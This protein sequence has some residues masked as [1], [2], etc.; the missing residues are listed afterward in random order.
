MRKSCIIPAV[1]LTLLIHVKKSIIILH[2]QIVKVTQLA[3]GKAKVRS[4][5][6]S[7]VWF[8]LFFSSVLM[9]SLNYI[10]WQGI[11][12]SKSYIRINVLFKIIAYSTF[13]SP[14]KIKLIPVV[15]R[16]SLA[17]FQVPQVCFYIY[18]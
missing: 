1:P 12:L 5:A 10:C 16:I 3:T 7:S 4:H 15:I 11:I 2:Y 13:T 6:C 9:S 17:L 18:F 14:G 8:R